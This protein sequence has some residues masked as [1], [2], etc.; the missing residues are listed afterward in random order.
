MAI[1]TVAALA[2][3][4]AFAVSPSALPS[5]T[6]I[7]VA[8]AARTQERPPAKETDTAF[9]QAKATGK[10]VPIESL[11][12][13][14][15]E[16]AA[17]PDGHLALTNHAEQQRT[18]KDGSWAVL[19]A[20]LA[21]NADGTYSPRASASSLV[22]SKGG[23]GPLATMISSDGKKLALTAPFKLPAPNIDG[24]SLLYPSVTSDTDLK[25]TATKAGGLT[26]VLV[27]KTQAAA[28]DPAVKDLHFGTVVDGVTVEADQGGNLAARG[29]DG[30]ARWTAPTPQMWDST[31]ATTAPKAQTLT[32]DTG[33]DPQ[34][35]R[36]RSD[37]SGPGSSA[38]VSSMP[39]TAGQDGIDLTLDQ[40][41]I[42]HGTAPF[43]IDPAWV[44]WNQSN[45]SWTW[46]QSAHPGTSNWNRS[47]SADSDHPGVG[48]CAYY[49]NGGSCSPSD[50]YR[51]FF[52]FDI[53]PISGAVVHYATMNLQE[54]VSADWSCTNSYP[55]D[56]Y[57]TSAIAGDTTWNKKPWEM[58]GPLGR[59]TIGGSG[60]SGCYN[61]VP[62]SYDITGTLQ[63]YTNNGQ[64]TFGLYGDE[65]NQYAFKR[66]DYRPSLYIE[67]DRTPS[68]PTGQGVWPLPK[69]VTPS[70]TTQA[71]G[72][73]NSN[74]WA[75]LGAGT[76][77]NGVV[78]LNAT[79][80]STTQGQLYTWNHIW[81]YQ[82]Q[83]VPDVASGYSAL[84]PNGGT[85]SF[86]VPG[87]VIM[88]GHSYGYSIMATDQLPGTPWSQPTPTCYFKVDL[89]APTVSF[90]PTVADTTKQF[91]PSGNGQTPKIYAGQSGAV[92][93]TV[94]D[95][96]PSGLHTSG[97]ACLRWGWDPQLAD[98]AWQCGTAM[99]T[100]GQIPNIT[101]TH[102]GTNILY[103]Q[104]EDNA[105]N[106]S[107]VAQYAFYAPWNP[108]GPSPVFG[109]V[110][111]DTAADIVAPDTAGNLR[112]FTVPGNPLATKPATT[113]AAKPANTP[114]TDG[115]TNSA[116]D[117][118]ADYQTT[119]RGS[120]SGGKNV[121]DL[122]VHKPGSKNLYVYWNPGSTG[123]PG[124]FDKRS[125]LSKP[126]CDSAITDCSGYNSTDW[127][128]TLEVAASGD[129]STTNLDTSKNFLNRTGL[130]TVETS[131]DGNGALWFYPAVG[132]AT[133]GSPTKIAA[134][135]WKGWNLISPGDW[136]GQGHPGLWRRNAGNG[137]LR[138]YTFNTGTITVTPPIGLPVNYPTITGIATSTVI[139]TGITAATWPTVGSDGD[140]TGT[141][142]PTLWGI[143]T[144]HRIQIWTGAPTT[145]TVSP[146]VYQGAAT[147]NIVL[148]TTGGADQWQLSGASTNNGTATDTSS[149]NPAT[150][151][152]SIT[153]EAD[154]K[155]ATNGAST[156]N[157]SSYFKTTNPS[158]DTSQSYSVSVWAK[159]SNLNNYQTFV[160]Q[161]GN[162]RG[163]YY[164]Q[165]SRAF[166]AWAFVSPSTD[167]IATATYY[168]ATASTPPEIG[169]WT[170]LVATY[171]AP[172]HTM[173]LYVNGKF[174]GGS[175][176]PNPWNATQATTIGAAATVNYPVDSQV[177]GSAS[178]VR[179]FPYVLTADQINALYTS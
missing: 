102:W 22:L 123:I 156:L 167:D 161:N 105:G 101:A 155:G 135:G 146:G 131:P 74:D 179:T 19:D 3:P 90:P 13:E 118:W 52:Q 159:I 165:Y 44:P 163:S 147:P 138:G 141:G 2:T 18:K 72:D 109:D 172:S 24:D 61:N 47:G 29:S 120:L 128:T 110:T 140:L 91:P 43:Y 168:A 33:T 32:Q 100:G 40:N 133:F 82:Q 21:T 73:G 87:N 160:T 67:Y 57:L 16:T 5:Q 134:T 126:T 59:V 96:N 39:V 130:F 50:T 153:Y 6:E 53:T 48:L 17:T 170:Y 8:T 84:T 42:A 104:A 11:T 137:E 114:P 41:L 25:V 122:I 88:D 89:A 149:I 127:A 106:P 157:G 116:G 23:D 85:A 49:P 162:A 164:L 10:K 173:S 26:T 31:I 113:L 152:G 64:L 169:K 80:F 154:H 98:A 151:N 58:G 36:E 71:C 108:N 15:S 119:H 83:G 28:A 177:T 92:P 148:S 27:L 111:G 60:H 143:T 103:I 81:D 117:S 46:I 174:V 107:G 86:S 171:D 136:A 66:L 51:S 14:F 54:Y 30:R 129:P 150:I 77:Q 175:T 95:S 35:A 121:D 132:D 69:T 76:N 65:G 7:D 78:Q 55:V 9:A 97:L 144:D 99:P 70:Q 68:T 124:V 166:N 79:V 93:V 112:A 4:V 125:T 12:T 75:W 158:V 45:S 34:P 115:G 20:S 176:N 145:A 62:F 37:A 63:Q 38:K 94:T 1:A 178:D 142:H 139:G 56:L